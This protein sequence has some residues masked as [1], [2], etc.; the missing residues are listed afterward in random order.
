[1]KF[2]KFRLTIWDPFLIT[3][4]IL[5]IQASFY[6]SLAILIS[7]IQSPSLNYIFTYQINILTLLVYLINA[8]CGSFYLWSFVGRA[9]PCLDYTVTCYFLHFLMSWTYN[10][11]LPNTWS[12]WIINFVA[13]SLMTFGG[14]YFCMKSEIIAIPL[15]IS[16]DDL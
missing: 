12:W 4:Q 5:T 11:F 13:A 2:G 1:M 14:E 3:L 16:T 7:A 8:T 9:K 6:S 10:G 15:L